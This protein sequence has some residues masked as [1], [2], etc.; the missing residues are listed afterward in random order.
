MVDAFQPIDFLPPTAPPQCDA[1]AGM[2]DRN[3]Y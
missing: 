3:Q 2:S 1:C